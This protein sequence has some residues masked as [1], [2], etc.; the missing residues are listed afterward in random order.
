M[1]SGVLGE[2]REM[3]LTLGS[4]SDRLAI[5]SVSLGG[6]EDR[7]DGSR[8]A[9]GSLGT[10][11]DGDGDEAVARGGPEVLDDHVLDH[12]IHDSNLGAD[13]VSSWFL[14]ARKGTDLED[15]VDVLDQ[16]KVGAVEN[17]LLHVSSVVESVPSSHQLRIP[18][19]SAAVLTQS[20]PS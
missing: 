9:L 10:E 7:L 14:R 12:T 2:D 1:V 3:V 4:S 15:G 11:E 16:P 18:H 5:C 19:P 8:G 13:T 20:P 6:G 17:V